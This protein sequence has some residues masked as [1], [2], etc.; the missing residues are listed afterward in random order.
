M[1]QVEISPNSQ[2]QL[3]NSKLI[4]DEDDVSWAMMVLTSDCIR[5]LR[6][7]FQ[8]RPEGIDMSQFVAIMF[9]FIPSSAQDASQLDISKRLCTLFRRIDVN[10]TGVMKWDDFVTHSL[11][12]S[13]DRD[14]TEVSTTAV[15][16]YKLSESQPFHLNNAAAIDQMFSFKEIDSIMMCET[17]RNSFSI[18][19]AST[20]TF[21]KEYSGPGGN[22]IDA[23][24]LPALGYIGTVSNEL[25][26]SF[27]DTV[28]F[29]KRQQLPISKIHTALAWSEM[30]R[31]LYSASID[32]EVGES[33]G[34]MD[35]VGLI[36]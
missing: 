15:A 16:Q 13:R 3:E 26:M 17:T 11:D 24:C 7:Y 9:Q 23:T 29:E 12:V 6:S 33:N 28:Y 20:R 36:F 5:K 10:S 31:T 4:Q 1:N 21:V 25:A 18:F 27:W 22:I 14:L 2:D 30:Y 19:D 32:G 8:T 34:W 35:V